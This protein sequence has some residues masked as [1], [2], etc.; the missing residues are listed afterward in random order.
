VKIGVECRVFAERLPGV[1][2]NRQRKDWR[3]RSPKINDGDV[4]HPHRRESLARGLRARLGRLECNDLGPEP[5]QHGGGVAEPTRHIDS[6]PSHRARPRAPAACSQAPRASAWRGSA[7]AMPHN[8]C[9]LMR[10]SVSRPGPPSSRRE[11]VGEEL[12]FV[13]HLLDDPPDAGAP[14]RSERAA[15]ISATRPTPFGMM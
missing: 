15:T 13:P 8:A 2:R 3:D 12:P 9:P 10:S 4:L 1:C 11:C 14:I 6:P 7:P 5:R